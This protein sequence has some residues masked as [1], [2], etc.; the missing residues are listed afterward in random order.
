MQEGPPAQKCAN[1][2]RFT[3]ALTT[4]LPKACFRAASTVSARFTRGWAPHAEKTAH[5]RARCELLCDAKAV[6]N[7]VTHAVSLSS[8]HRQGQVSI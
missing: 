7:R 1:T 5:E 6:C 8:E 2:V 4:V 3:A